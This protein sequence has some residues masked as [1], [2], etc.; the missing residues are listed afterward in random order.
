[1]A[2]RRS[3]FSGNYDANKSCAWWQA[4]AHIKTVPGSQLNYWFQNCLVFRQS[5]IKYLSI[6]FSKIIAN[7][8]VWTDCVFS[9]RPLFWSVSLVLKIDY[10]VFLSVVCS[11][12]LSSISC[13]KALNWKNNKKLFMKF[14]FLVVVKIT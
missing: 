14:L 11:V 8:W 9:M 2:C 10:L 1:M 4:L 7:L 6:W 5:V 3:S 13:R 12:K